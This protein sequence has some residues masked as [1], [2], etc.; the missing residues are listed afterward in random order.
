[1][2]WTVGRRIIAG[3]AL[4]VLLMLVITAIA[5][6]ALN[7]TTTAYRDSITDERAQLVGAF[8]V[9]GALRNANVGFLR[10]LLERREADALARDSALELARASLEQLQAAAP[11]QRAV[12]STVAT[13]LEQWTQSTA[14]AMSAARAGNDEEVTRIRN[15]LATPARQTLEDAVERGSREAREQTDAGIA[16]AH[17][18]AETSQKW[19]VATM[20]VALLTAILSAYLLYRAI[21]HPLQETSAVIATSA[22]EILAT[23]TEQASGATQSLTAVTETAATLDEVVQTSEQAAERARAVAAS[24][25]RAAEIGRQGR[26]A[27]EQSSAAM[28]Q[29]STQVNSIGESILQLAEQAQA[30][31]EIITTVNEL[32]EQTNLLALNAA[33]E[34]AR[35][36]EQG[37]GFSVVAAEVRSL[38]EQSKAATVR[39][40]QI[41]GEIQRATSAAVMSTEQGNK[42]VEEGVRQ[43]REAGQTIRTLADAAAGAAQAAAQ[44]SASAGQQSSGMAQIKQAVASIQQA[45]QQNLA[46]TRQAEAAARELNRVGGR[47][48][49]LVGADGRP[50]RQSG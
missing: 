24:A 38:A 47:L 17:G 41:L 31:G 33:I 18:T 4:S 10:F 43:V 20:A 44:I 34:A 1:V 15:E 9:R 8:E 32:A 23:T 22:S 48:I 13:S 5:V 45:A 16:A 21:S 3:F 28:E 49:E 14:A 30:I 29:V 40:R 50:G 37:R 19:L 46:A 42:Q 25:Q 7:R 11:E 39:V 35:A 36:G 26:E 2:T 6:W 27:V 12:W